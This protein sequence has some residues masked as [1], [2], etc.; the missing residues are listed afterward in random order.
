MKTKIF[1]IPFL[2]FLSLPLSYAR[3]LVRTEQ[4]SGKEKREMIEKIGGLIKDHYVFPELGA[5][6][7]EETLALAGS[8][9]FDEV[10]DPKEFGEKVTAA[11]QELTKDKHFYFRLVEKTDLAEDEGGS[12]HHPARY[13]RLGQKEHLGVFRLDWID[14]G[15]GYLDYR[16][17]Y[18]PSEAKK[19]FLGALNFLSSAN[20]LIIDLRKNQGG[21]GSL[22]PWMCSYF[23]PYPT[24][25]TGTYNRSDG[26]T[27]EWW[28]ME[29]V[30]G[31]RLLDV[32]LFLLIGKNT[33]SAAEYLA[34]DLKVRKRA[35][36]VG[37]PTRGGAHS[38][39]LYPVGDR[40]EIYIPTARAVNPVTGTN[41]EGIGVLPDVQVPAEKALETATEL[42]KKAALE[43]GKAKNDNLARSVEKM[44]EQLDQAESLYQKG[45]DDEARRLLDAVFQSISETGMLNEFFIDVLAYHYSSH[46]SQ[47]MATEILEKQTELFPESP[48]AYVSLA[49]EY[50]RQGERTQANKY[51]EKV[52]ELDKN[53]SIARQMLKRLD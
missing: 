9:K 39:D 2:L 48:R 23:L 46:Q 34:Y 37:E 47:K 33:F 52:L 6:Y 14:G 30:E 10:S 21:G 43:Y 17:F 41:W 35:T 24:Q 42:A 27:E 7:G 45:R 36:L 25:L 26:V 1:T 50:F 16:R 15:I 53:H 28:T 51:F 38:T 13:F 5:K 18:Y 32:P 29:H 11:L 49:L 20:A 44:Q 31:K 40:F 8:D 22:I 19:M 4:L 3:T 12:L